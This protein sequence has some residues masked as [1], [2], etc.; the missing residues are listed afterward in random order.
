MP[1]SCLKRVPRGPQDDPKGQHVAAKRLSKAQD[2]R[3]VKMDP[4]EVQAPSDDGFG[5]NSESI[6]GSKISHCFSLFE[7]FFRAVSVFFLVKPLWGSF[8]DYYSG[9]K[10]AQE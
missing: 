2:G 5:V 9:T 1:P 6:L 10:S 7:T 4:D 8:G 3:R